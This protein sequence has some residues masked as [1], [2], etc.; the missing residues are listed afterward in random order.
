MIKKNGSISISIYT[1]GQAPRRRR[2]WACHRCF[3]QGFHGYG[4]P[5]PPCESSVCLDGGMGAEGTLMQSPKA[6]DPDPPRHY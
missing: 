2:R 6:D 3:L 4:V 5:H 1:V